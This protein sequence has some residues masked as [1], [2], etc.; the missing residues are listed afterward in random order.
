VRGRCVPVKASNR[1]ARSCTRYALLHGGFGYPKSGYAPASRTSFH[2]TGRLGKRALTPG[3]YRLVAVAEDAN[4]A[5]SA[6]LRVNFR[7]NR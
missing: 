7:I 1:T 5:H 2:F 4:H 3:R 6:A